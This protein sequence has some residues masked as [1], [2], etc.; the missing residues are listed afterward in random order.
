MDETLIFG[1]EGEKRQTDIGSRKNSTIFWDF[2][3]G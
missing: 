2:V 3:I 1:S